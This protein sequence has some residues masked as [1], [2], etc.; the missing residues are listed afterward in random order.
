MGNDTKTSAH[1]IEARVNR[2]VKIR[3]LPFILLLYVVAFLDRINIGFAA[4]T[5]RPE[6]GISSHQFGFLAGIFFVS[7]SI[8]EIPSNLLLHKIGALTRSVSFSTGQVVC[9][10]G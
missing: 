9:L 10:A 8:C 7:Y 1:F 6:L 2:K 4:L 5:M 3:I